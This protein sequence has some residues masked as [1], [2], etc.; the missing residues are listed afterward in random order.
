M[1][2]INHNQVLFRAYNNG[3][4]YYMRDATHESEKK[5]L[6]CIF[7]SN[8]EE[9]SSWWEGGIPILSSFWQKES[10]SKKAISCYRKA[11]NLIFLSPFT[12]LQ[13]ILTIKLKANLIFKQTNDIL[14]K[15]YPNDL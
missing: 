1:Q 14:P 11:S 12:L 13:H 2:P 4:N 10:L 15:T 8:R 3:S 5:N 6:S 9:I 7:L